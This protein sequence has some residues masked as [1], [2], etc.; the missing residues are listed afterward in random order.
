MIAQRDID[1]GY[2]AVDTDYKI[3]WDEQVELLGIGEQM[4]AKAEADA[5]AA[6][7]AAGGGKPAPKAEH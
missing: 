1:V 2:D 7:R 5:E 3:N 4:R 6:A